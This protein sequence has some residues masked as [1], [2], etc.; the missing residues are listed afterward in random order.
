MRVDL[1]KGQWATLVDPDDMTHGVKMK[2][3]ALLPGPDNTDHFFVNEMRMRELMIAC[4]VTGWSLD[5][6]VPNGDPALLADVPGGAYDKLVEETEPHWR[7]L[8]FLR[9]GK[10]SSDSATSSPETESPAPSPAS[11]A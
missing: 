11:E 9:V 8:D 4:L 2:V 7:S 3:Q 5:L 6:P 10:T 1:P